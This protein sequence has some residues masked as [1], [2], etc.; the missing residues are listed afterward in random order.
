[1][2]Q[3]FLIIVAFVT[4]PFLTMAQR[5]IK[6]IVAAEL[7]AVASLTGY[8]GGL[9]YVH[10]L[11]SNLYVKGTVFYEMAK[12]K[13]SN[14]KINTLTVD[15]MAAYTLLKKPGIVYLNV[16]GGLSGILLDKVTD[17]DISDSRLDEINKPKTGGLIGGELEYYIT[18]NLSLILNLTQRYYF[19]SNAFG[20][21]RAFAMIGLRKGF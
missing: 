2:K 19:P 12:L 4:I 20:Q 18:G 3:H 21:Q 6:G 8:G 13:N 10:Y 15:A 16:I 5:H 7:D 14:T 9:S 17:S 1:M 11:Q